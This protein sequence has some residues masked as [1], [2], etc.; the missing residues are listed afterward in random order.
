M[1]DVHDYME[2]VAC[3][4]HLARGSLWHCSSGD[5]KLGDCRLSENNRVWGRGCLCGSLYAVVIYGL[6][7]GGYLLLAEEKSGSCSKLLAV[8]GQAPRNQLTSTWRHPVPCSTQH[9]VHPTTPWAM[10]Y[11]C[12]S[13]FPLVSLAACS[14]AE[15]SFLP[16]SCT[17]RSRNYHTSIKSHAAGIASY[18]ARPQPDYGAPNMNSDLP[19]FTTNSEKIDG[20]RN[21]KRGAVQQHSPQQVQSI[22]NEMSCT[23]CAVCTHAPEQLP[24]R[25]TVQC[26]AMSIQVALLQVPSNPQY[27]PIPVKC[28]TKRP[29]AKWDAAL[30]VH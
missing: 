3:V 14:L 21:F 9:L 26:D 27:A 16:W 12:V 13:R 23:H 18:P 22:C 8:S 11:P 24:A 15:C 1:V 2:H 29:L 30:P 10:E 28:D 5:C 17:R 19:N 25:H 20:V 4:G 7:I 6:Q